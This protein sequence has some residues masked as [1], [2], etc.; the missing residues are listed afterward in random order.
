MRMNKTINIFFV[1]CSLFFIEQSFGCKKALKKNKDLYGN[2]RT[3]DNNQISIS[4]DNQGDVKIFNGNMQMQNHFDGEAH[5]SSCNK[6]R[7]GRFTGHIDKYPDYD[8]DDNMIL[9]L[10]GS[11]YFGANIPHLQTVIFITDSS[12]RIIFDDRRAYLDVF[13]EYKAILSPSW[14]RAYSLGEAG[15]TDYYDAFGLSSATTYQVRFQSQAGGALSP[16]S[17]IYTFN[18]L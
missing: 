11:K 15:S 13:I 16:Y 12:A 5:V 9:K 4:Q 1:F 14:N 7:I 3:V 10:E 8:I 18:T 17:T 6:L 2:W